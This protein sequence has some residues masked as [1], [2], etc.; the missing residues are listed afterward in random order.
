L[1]LFIGGAKSK[2][3][4]TEY[5]CITGQFFCWQ[6]VTHTALAEIKQQEFAHCQRRFAPQFLLYIF[7]SSLSK[8]YDIAL[9]SEIALTFA[10][11]NTRMTTDIPLGLLFGAIHPMHNHK[12]KKQFY[13]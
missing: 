11:N 7:L 4:L 8:F 1:E 2:R 10:W 6:L 5:G 12:W 9:P 3:Q 13:K